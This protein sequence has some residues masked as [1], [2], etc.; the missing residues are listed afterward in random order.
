[1]KKILFCLAAFAALVSCTKENPVDETPTVDTPAVEYQT[2][3]FEATAPSAEDANATK[4]TLVDGSLVHWVK[5]DEIK[6]LFFPNAGWGAYLY[7][8][9]V[10]VGANGV[11]TTTFESETSA[12][13]YFSG[14]INWSHGSEYMDSGIAIYPSTVEASCNR[15]AGNY[16]Y[17][18]NT[19]IT[20]DLSNEQT[21]VENSFQNGLAFSY[22]EIESEYKEDFIDN[23]A[24]LA[25]KNTCAL[26]KVTLPADAKDIMSVKVES[27]DANLAG[28]YKATI[29][30]TDKSQKPDFPLV[31][32]DYGEVVS[33]HV[34]LSAP[35]GETLKAGAS[36]YIVTWPGTHS[37]GLTFTFTNSA[38]LP[39]TKQV[40]QEVVLEASKIDHF[41]FKSSFTFEHIFE[42]SDDNF[43][44]EG[45]A[46]NG[47][48]TVTSS[49]NW[50]A[51][52]DSDW[53]TVTPT[54]GAA[55]E[56]ASTVS[57]NATQN[58]SGAERTARITITAGADTKVVTVTQAAFVPEL[59]IERYGS[60]SELG[61]D[62]T[63]FQFVTIKS[64]TDWTLSCDQTWLTI[65][66]TQ[67]GVTTSSTVTLTA[68]KNESTSKRTATLYLRDKNN[69][70]EKTF[71]VTQAGRPVM[72]YIV[73]QVT[74]ASA[75]ENDGL[76]VIEFFG[77]SN[78]YWKVDN[79][80]NVHKTYYG[81][82]SN[83]FSAEYV[84]RFEKTNYSN[85][86][87]GYNSYS[88]GH[89][90]SV[91]LNMYF[92]YWNLNFTEGSKTDLLF[93]NKYGTEEG[94]EIDIYE[95]YNYNTLYWT[96]SKLAWG[97]TS[98][99]SNSN[100]KWNIYKVEVR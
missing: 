45:T 34:T 92:E 75:L 33:K 28:D 13:A 36:Y 26:I 30:T 1:M 77:Q 69:T 8:D 93:E 5:G 38:G 32:K 18:N 4:T 68:A 88:T 90:W 73:N 29:S 24:K 62:G 60:W 70:V 98:D 56:S 84:Y 19:V 42:V 40:S 66:T 82:T 7:E 52:S 85:P 81:S 16:M 17:G 9:D 89:L 43:N 58:N 51:S 95:H 2:I 96:G 63:D 49:R 72:Y 48:F 67:G 78:Y 25:F 31:L 47:S 61:Y 37:N 54:S 11:F 14:E 6:I 44:F 20:Y 55:S 87:D 100:R 97:T 23:K 35:A 79:Y 74:E 71:A 10:T 99:S 15:P 27:A 59:S 41:N 83:G 94:A 3:T 12:T 80:G 65:G 22:A 53:L 57:F 46:S 91:K 76:Y 39:L 50:T 21:A 86:I 64:N